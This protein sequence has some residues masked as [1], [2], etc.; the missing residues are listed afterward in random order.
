MVSPALEHRI[1]AK[2]LLTR[3]TSPQEAAR[4]VEDGMA[5][6]IGTGISSACPKTFFTALANEFK[7]KGK[8]KLFTGGP[9]PDEVDGLLVEADIV[10]RRFGQFKNPLLLKAANDRSI[11]VVEERTGILPHQVRD[12][13]F[14]KIDIAVIQATAITEQGHIIPTTSCLDAPSY[15]VLANRVIVEINP[16]IPEEIEG[17]HD[18]Y[19]PEVAPDRKPIPIVHAGDRIGT[20]YIPVDPDKI[21]AII[22]SNIPDNPPPRPPINETSQKVAE[23]LLEFF[24][25]EVKRGRLPTSLLPL[26]FGIGTIPEA[27]AEALCE[28]VF[29]DIEIFSG[30]VGD[31]GLDLIDAGKVKA[32][33]VAALYLSEG[34]FDRFYKDI[35][36]YKSKIILRPVVIADCPELIARLGCIAINGAIEVD[37]YGHVNSSHI[38]GTRIISGVGGSCD[39][40]WNA[41]LSIVVLPSVARKGVISSIVPMVTHVD[42]PEH[43]IDLIITEQGYADLRGLSP[44]ERAKKIIDKCAHP[45]YKDILREYLQEAI[46]NRGGHEPHILEKAFNLHIA[47]LKNGTMRS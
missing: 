47:Y 17:I 16:N 18:I 27:I 10:E 46:E 40:L 44:V 32:L 25:N 3:V 34:G 39:F 28:S 1:R 2:R 22:E 37:I 35:S 29:N 23:Y 11:P 26:Q 38:Q 24:T 45:S 30:A 6:G 14:G 42:H 41:Y 21:V 13:R 12:G 43:A 8:I 31:G 4:L 9:V 5:V 20:P 36:R 33:S 15:T 7:G 19:I